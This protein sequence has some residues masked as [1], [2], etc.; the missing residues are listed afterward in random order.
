[1]K[2]VAAATLASASL[3]SGAPTIPTVTIAPGVEL[4]M[5]GLGTWQYNDSVA[6]A[7]TLAALKMGYTHID[8]ALGYN[9][10][11]GVGKALEASGRARASYF[12][13]SKIPGGLNTSATNAALEL[14]LQ[15]LGLTYVDLMLI[16]FPA[17]WGGD[18]GAA[19]RVEEWK[20]MEAFQKAGKAKAIGVS[21][22]C[23][24]HLEDILAIATVK[25]AVNQVQYHVRCVYVE[26]ENC[27][28]SHDTHAL[29]LF[30]SGWHGHGGRQRYR[31]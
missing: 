31:R 18:G 16:H 3:V 28:P 23:K 10:Q 11:V 1:M 26:R 20:A 30:S 17:T 25:P 13:T 22:Y 9:N 15:Q 29:H 27:V 6:G 19:A 14:S 4:P 2:I 21:H 5:A 7:A 12:I 8:T 24:H